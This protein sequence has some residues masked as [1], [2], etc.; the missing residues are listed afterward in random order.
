M[1]HPDDEVPN[2]SGPFDD[3]F[4][5]YCASKVRSRNAT[6]DFVKAQKPH[7]DVINVM[8]TFV[9]GRSELVQ[10]PEEAVT[11][12][13][14]KYAL[15]APL[16][17]KLDWPTPGATVHVDDVARIHILSLDPKVK[18][19]QNFS[20]SSGYN[21]YNSACEIVRKRFPEAV[22][23]GVFSLDG[24]LPSSKALVDASKTEDVL[25]FKFLDWESQVFSV[26]EHYLELL[27]KEEE[28][29]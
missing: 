1:Y 16:G 2:P 13:T 25:G 19:S 27:A 9:I 7:F 24:D 4:A 28:K 22:K 8:P 26:A 17:K 23:K 14:N 3:A 5:A 10:S 12:G 29:V 6:T 20:A 11:H 21:K 15:L 18:G